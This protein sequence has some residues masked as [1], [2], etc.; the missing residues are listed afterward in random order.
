MNVNMKPEKLSMRHLSHLIHKV[1]VSISMNGNIG[2]FSQT[3]I[4]TQEK[5]ELGQV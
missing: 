1:D 5:V 4:L 3:G 2:L